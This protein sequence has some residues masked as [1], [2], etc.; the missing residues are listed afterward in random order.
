[1]VR[2]KSFFYRDR[3]EERS[4]RQRQLEPDA[5][6]PRGAPVRERRAQAPA[7]CRRVDF[8]VFARGEE[9]RGVDL[10]SVVGISVEREDL[11]EV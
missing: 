6:P 11:G 9:G 1:M 2:I 5:A 8:F 4:L 3:E 7:K 10:D